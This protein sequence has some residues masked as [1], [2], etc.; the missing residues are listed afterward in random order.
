MRLEGET[1]LVH[2]KVPFRAPKAAG[3]FIFRLFNAANEGA[4]THN[5]LAYT[6]NP[7]TVVLAE[8][9]V[10]PQIRYASEKLSC[11]ADNFILSSDKNAVSH[12]QA[13]HRLHQALSHLPQTAGG[14][15]ISEEALSLLLQCV[16]IILSL[17]DFYREKIEKIEL[18]QRENGHIMNRLL[19]FEVRNGKLFHF[20]AAKFLNHLKG[21]HYLWHI[22]SSLHEDIAKVLRRYCPLQQKFF[23]SAE[24]IVTEIQSK[25]GFSPTFSST[26][27]SEF[28][29]R[30]NSPTLLS[31]L[32]KGLR[33]KKQ[34]L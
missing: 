33:S 29:S 7:I 26:S 19:L 32:D 21:S 3:Q 11:S 8:K 5:T 22:V 31:G 12:C 20:K 24:E 1:V 28:V 30:T 34:Y 25:F 17:I 15:C 13:I 4:E 10:L 9:D 18:L 16:S 2:G 14:S 6:Q 23:Q 27:L